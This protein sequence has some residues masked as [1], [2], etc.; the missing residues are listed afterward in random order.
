THKVSNGRSCYSF[1]MCPGGTV[2]AASSEEGHLVVNGM[3][4]YARDKE[5]A[6]S[7]VVVSVSPED[8]DSDHPLAGI[9]F[10]RDIERKAFELTDKT[11]KA[12]VQLLK[13]FLEDR[14]SSSIGSVIPS[15][16]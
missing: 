8:F 16:P 10:Q 5:N 4:E 9:E 13:D 6:N 3:S 14:E 1:C 7:A 2:V 12:P 11:H 15:C